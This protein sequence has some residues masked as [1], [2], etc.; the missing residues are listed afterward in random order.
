VGCLSQCYD[1]AVG[2]VSGVWFP[3]GAGIFLFAAASRLALGPT[4][5]RIQWVAGEER[6]GPEDDHVHV[7]PRLI[8][9]RI[10]PIIVWDKCQ[11]RHTFAIVKIK[12]TRINY[13]Y[14]HH[15]HHHYYYMPSSHNK[16][17]LQTLEL[18]YMSRY[19][20]FS[21][22]RHVSDTWSIIRHQVTVYAPLV[23]FNSGIGHK[24]TWRSIIIYKN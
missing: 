7:V 16:S 18:N 9:I 22:K 11:L 3:A 4:Q 23:R 5:S 14:Y 17:V 24:T 20:Y 12:I 10:K 2:C 1:Y 15:H 13:Y 21:T 8:L 19:F 6:P